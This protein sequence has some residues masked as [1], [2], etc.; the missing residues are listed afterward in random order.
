MPARLIGHRPG[1]TLG[2]RPRRTRTRG[3]ATRRGAGSA[4][5]DRVGRSPSRHSTWDPRRASVVTHNRHRLGEVRDSGVHDRRAGA[6]RPVALSPH[7]LG[8]ARPVGRIARRAPVVLCHEHQTRMG[9]D[10]S[11]T[12]QHQQSATEHRVQIDHERCPRSFGDRQP[13]HRRERADRSQTRSG[14]CADK[15]R[16]DAPVGTRASRHERITRGRHRVARRG[17]CPW[18]T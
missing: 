3:S 10:G 12:A 1:R 6:K 18:V 5:P 15:R 16:K 9:D 13:A 11:R 14:L 2:A 4:S 8:P 7:D 17:S